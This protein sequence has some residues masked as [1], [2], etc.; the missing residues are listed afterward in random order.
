MVKQTLL[1]IFNISRNP[2]ELILAF[3]YNS[4]SVTVTY[5]WSTCFHLLYNGLQIA[6]LFSED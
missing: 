3:D 5:A 2:A 4:G 6:P 1:G